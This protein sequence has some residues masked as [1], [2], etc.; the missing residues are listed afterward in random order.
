MEKECDAI[1]INLGCPQ[2]IAKRGNYGAFLADSQWELIHS[3]IQSLHKNLSIPVIC[4]IRVFDDRE[5]TIRYA[6]MIE[7]AGCQ[8]LTVHGRTKEQKGHFMGLADWTL[9]RDIKYFFSPSSSLSFPF[10]PLS[11]SPFLEKLSLP[12]HLFISSLP[13]GFPF[14]FFTSPFFFSLNL[15]FWKEQRGGLL[16]FSLFFLFPSAMID[17]SLSSLQ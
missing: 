15:P 4:K 10:L 14:S 17:Q 2:N 3:L 9:I 6:K 7:S 12:S 13:P 16:S 1:C 8:L 5:K 11:T